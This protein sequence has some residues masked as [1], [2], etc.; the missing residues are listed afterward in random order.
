MSVLRVPRR[1]G[2]AVRVTVVALAVLASSALGLPS[3]AAAPATVIPLS[4]PEVAVV[5]YP[6]ENTG[7]LTTD[8]DAEE[9]ATTPV[10]VEWTGGLEIQIPAPL[11]GSAMEVILE[12]KETATG[13]ATRTLTTADLSLTDLGGGRFGITFPVDDL[14]NGPVGDLLL[15]GI[16]S[17]EPG[18]ES[19][20]VAF[21]ELVFSG[22]GPSVVDL[23]PQ[24]LAI[25]S[26]PCPLSSGTRCP[27]IPVDA[28][29]TFGITVPP[30]SLLRL[31][32]LGTLDAMD[33]RLERLDPDGLP[34]GSDPIVLTDDPSLVTVTDPHNATVTVPASTPGGAYG[35]TLVHTTG[36]AGSISVTFGELNVSGSYAV[37]PRIVNAGLRSETGWGEVPEAADST[38]PLVVTGS[39]LLVLAGGAVAAA[40][41]PRRRAAAGTTGAAQTCGG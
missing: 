39:G 30:E 20:G 15:T 16:T 17:T 4:P 37:S 35:L 1:R 12:L 26:V 13:P 36:T 32:G 24:I 29:S 3:A 11:D 2:T 40:L 23:A 22:T 41:R 27:A 21:Y 7:P 25:G 10:E 6:V 34:N 5:L 9:V 28:G 8:M 18:V 33:L 14:A 19:A 31:L 38:S